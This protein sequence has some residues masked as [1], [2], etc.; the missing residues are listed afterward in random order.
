MKKFS[1]NLF[2]KFRIIFVKPGHYF[3]YKKKYLR[4]LYF[5]FSKYAHLK[6][7]ASRVHKKN[8]LNFKMNNYELIDKKKGYKLI[9]CSILNK[10]NTNVIQVLANIEKDLKKIDVNKFKFSD[11][12]IVKIKSSSDFNKDSPEFKFV[13]NKY[14]IEIVSRYLNCIP[15]LT[16]LSLWY[17]PNSKSIKK[18]SQ[19]YH[20]D[21]EDYKQV[22]GFLFI[23]E[24]DKNTGPLSIINVFQSNKIQKY[25]NYN[26]TEQNKRVDDDIINN[27][28][29]NFSIDENIITGKPGDLI[30]CDTSSCFHYG[31]R[32]GKKPRI[33]LAFQYLTPFGFSMNW[34][35][36][37]S[38]QIPY[39]NLKYNTTTLINKVLGKEV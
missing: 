8:F 28:K 11:Q 31:S 9:K 22:K 5:L 7:Y 12:G 25:L 27:S 4:K 10:N 30:L 20:L 29:K 39:K 26:M 19:E 35:W 17:S 23:N 36:K 18:S 38:N 6:T 1:I 32:L 2:K 13:T 3:R 14:L 15:I 34:N 16:N 37:K 33:I 24:I 21:H